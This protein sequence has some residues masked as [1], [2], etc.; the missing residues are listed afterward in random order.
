M[1]IILYYMKLFFMF[2]DL[3]EYLKC[4]VNCLQFIIDSYLDICICTINSGSIFLL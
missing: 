3:N 2:N 4:A 1:M